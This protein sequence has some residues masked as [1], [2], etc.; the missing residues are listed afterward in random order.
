MILLITSSSRAVEC[1]NFIHEATGEAAQV[2]SSLRNATTQLRLAEFSAVVV[3]QSLVDSDPDDSERVLQHMGTAI[4][5]YVNFAVSGVERVARELRTAMQ[6]YKKEIEAAR[7]SAQQA[8]RNDLKGPV[9]ALLLSCE[10]TLQTPGLP[11]SA[12]V[13]LRSIYELARE[14]RA[15]LGMAAGA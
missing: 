4:P 2:A 1:A 9:T 5:V 12:Q 6:R 14:L 7:Q 10:L 13:K 11:A 15:K 3:D 8:M